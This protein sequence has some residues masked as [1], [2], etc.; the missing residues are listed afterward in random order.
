MLNSSSDLIDTGIDVGLPYY[1]I[2]PDVGYHEFEL[3]SSF[4]LQDTAYINSP[5]D[6][7]YTGNASDSATYYWDFGSAT[8]ISGSGQGPYTVQWTNVGWDA[9]SLYVEESNA[10]SD[11][12]TNDIYILPAPPIIFSCFIIQKHEDSLCSKTATDTLCSGTLADIIYTGNASYSATYYW[13]FG[14]ATVISGSGQGPYM[15]QWP[16]GGWDAVSLYIEESNIASD[17]TTNDIYIL[18]NPIITIIPYPNDTVAINDTIVLTGDIASESYLWSNGDTTQSIKVFN[19]SPK[20]GSQSY[21][22]MVTDEMGC[23]GTDSITVQFNYPVNINDFPDEIEIMVYPNPVNDYLNIELEI[24]QQ[25][26]YIFEVIDNIGRPVI[27]ELR[28]FEP[29]T[30]KLHLNLNH[31]SPGFYILSVKSNKG[32]IAV[33]KII[34]CSNGGY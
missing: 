24:A 13:D 7:I 15:V 14:S 2:A 11:T 25:G 17:T 12:T 19:I 26:K 16:N 4:E 1:G 31:S 33:K 22:L 34:K 20:K 8:V 29:G 9:V 23:T 27:R 6:I 18:T 5:T 28:Y 30:Q 3:T 21:W 32:M 10:V